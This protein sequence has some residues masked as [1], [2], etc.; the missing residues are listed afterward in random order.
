[1]D[2]SSLRSKVVVA[3]CASAGFVSICCPVLPTAGSFIGSST[4]QHRRGR[5]HCANR[6]RSWYGR[7]PFV[8][9]S[10]THFY[11]SI[12]A[13]NC[14]YFLCSPCRSAIVVGVFRPEALLSLGPAIAALMASAGF[15][16]AKYLG[17]PER[18]KASHLITSD[19]AIGSFRYRKRTLAT[20]QARFMDHALV[21]LS[22]DRDQNDEPEWRSAA[23][24]SMHTKA[25]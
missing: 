4:L 21:P 15:L 11:A 24:I 9:Q 19:R 23:G 3:C 16:L 20:A 2:L 5:H 6:C 8:R 12:R 22:T 7:L 25:A 18:M 10:P 17:R 1:V 13:N 14:R